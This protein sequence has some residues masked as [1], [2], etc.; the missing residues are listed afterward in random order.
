MWKTNFISRCLG[1]QKFTPAVW[2]VCERASTNWNLHMRQLKTTQPYDWIWWI[3]NKTNNV[4]IIIYNHDQNSVLHFIRTLQSCILKLNSD[5]HLT[6]RKF[7]GQIKIVHR[8]YCE[9][10]RYVGI[11]GL[12]L[13]MLSGVLTSYFSAHSNTIHR[14]L[15]LLHLFFVVSLARRKILKSQSRGTN[16]ECPTCVSWSINPCHGLECSKSCNRYL[17]QMKWQTLKANGSKSVRSPHSRVVDADLG[18]VNILK[19]SIN[20]G[21]N[22]I[23]KGFHKPQI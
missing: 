20:R 15:K 16:F 21:A 1:N 10:T 14:I 7:I 18:A 4:L 2:L 3:Q 12:I 23:R 13:K 22:I 19:Y 5:L 9:I 6:L 17:W 11:I 8:K